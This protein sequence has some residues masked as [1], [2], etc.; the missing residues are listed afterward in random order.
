MIAL[1]VVP[2]VEPVVE[3]DCPHWLLYLEASPLSFELLAA[4]DHG[5]PALSGADQNRLPDEQLLWL[6]LS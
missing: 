5:D 6:G 2:V 1:P 3:I 4:L